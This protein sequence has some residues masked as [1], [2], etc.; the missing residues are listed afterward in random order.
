LS[1]P[2]AEILGEYCSLDIYDTL[3]GRDFVPGRC[4]RCGVVPCFL[5]V[6]DLIC[7]SCYTLTDMKT[8]VAYA[9]RDCVAVPPSPLYAAFEEV[10]CPTTASITE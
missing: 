9:T 8:V 5:S 2:G 6:G 4:R 3:C 1:K 10:R 7:I